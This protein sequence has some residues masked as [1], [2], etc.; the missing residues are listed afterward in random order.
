MA[1][2]ARNNTAAKATDNVAELGNHAADK[3]ADVAREAMD[4]TEN[5]ARRGVEFR[6]RTAG[7]ALG[8][9]V[10]M[11]RRSTEATAEVGQA[12]AE[13][14]KEQARSNVEAFQALTRT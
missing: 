10:A 4:K 14:V 6:Q 1:Q 13:L 7:A 2:I 5:M 12:F 9:E 3:G 11:V 8:A